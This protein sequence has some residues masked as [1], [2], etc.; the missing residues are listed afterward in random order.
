MIRLGDD[1][2]DQEEKNKSRMINGCILWWMILEIRKISGTQEVKLIVCKSWF[3]FGIRVEECCWS[4][5]G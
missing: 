2:L 4:V 1:V 3:G 5:R